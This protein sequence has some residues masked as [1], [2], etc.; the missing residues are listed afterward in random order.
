MTF[1]Q[2]ADL[3][4][5]TDMLDLF[6]ENG[7][8]EIDSAY[9]YNE[10]AT[11]NLLGEIYQSQPALKEKLVFAS[12]ANPRVYGGLNK[13]SVRKQCVGTLKRMGLDS[14]DVFYIH[15][16]DPDTPI[17][18]TLQSCAELH[19]E[20]KFKELGI[21]NFSKNAL[22]K[23]LEICEKN[24]WPKPTIYQGMYN[25]ITRSVET[26][27]LP[28][29]KAESIRFYAFNPLAGGLL[30]GKYKN[31]Q[32]KPSEG[33]FALRASYQN[34]Y[35]KESYFGALE[36]IHT[37]CEKAAIPMHSAALRWMRHHSALSSN[38]AL[39]IGASRLS[40]L[41]ANLNS[42]EE[43]PLPESI[44]SSFDNAW[45]QLKAES[46]QYYKD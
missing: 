16:P 36:Q 6:I 22:E 19:N 40:Q 24:H 18:E 15:M 7:H 5:S 46:P 39:I 9:V 11:E 17:N 27:L 20:G 14:M 4:A 29:L 21:S 13:E 35:W 23:I 37:N 12:K 33:R 1:A 32:D 26:E 8:H 45:I 41:R 42:I 43:G 34:R 3:D 44:L 30:T 2:Q 31:F 10:G 28:F 25:A 38:D